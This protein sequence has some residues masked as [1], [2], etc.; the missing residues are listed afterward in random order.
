MNNKTDGFLIKNVFFFNWG[1][2]GG[3][4]GRFGF[5]VVIFFAFRGYWQRINN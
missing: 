2:G 3:G 1:G 4:G 5:V